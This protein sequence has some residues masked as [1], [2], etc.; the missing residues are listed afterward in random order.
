MPIFE[1]TCEDCQAHF[2]KL[3]RSASSA[4][5]RCPQCGGGHTKKA[6][7]VFGTGRFGGD[8]LG[9]SVPSSGSCSPAGT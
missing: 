6:W 3:V 7:S 9:S 5:V 1:Y 2:E 4:E 8:S